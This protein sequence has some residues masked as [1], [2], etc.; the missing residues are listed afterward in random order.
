M[1]VSDDVLPK[2][3]NSNHCDVIT[4][5]YE[6]VED[7]LFWWYGGY[8]LLVVLAT[9]CLVVYGFSK[10]LYKSDTLPLGFDILNHYFIEKLDLHH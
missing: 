5:V 2:G 3:N 6:G 9:T 1:D 8:A 4:L 10:I 7:M